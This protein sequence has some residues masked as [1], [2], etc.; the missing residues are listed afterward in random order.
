MTATLIPLGS[1][2]RETRACDQGEFMELIPVYFYCQTGV[3]ADL[4]PLGAAGAATRAVDRGEE[5]ELNPI[6][7]WTP[8]GVRQD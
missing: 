8:S 2:G 4:V 5:T 3:G 7:E 6:F 1:A